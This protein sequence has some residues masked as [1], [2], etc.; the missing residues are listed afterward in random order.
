[1]GPSD[2]SAD[3]APEQRAPNPH[4]VALQRSP[5]THYA[6]FKAKKKIT[7]RLGADKAPEH[8]PL[9]PHLLVLPAQLP[10]P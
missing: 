3:K 2:C 8:S 1:M 9:D 7:F 5:G 10:L 4:L 6:D